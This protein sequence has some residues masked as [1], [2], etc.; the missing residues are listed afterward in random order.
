MKIKIAE[1]AGFCMGVRRAVNLVLKA[2]NEKKS[3]IYTYGPLIHNPQTLEL[4]A[5]LG[6]KILDDKTEKMPSS[7]ICII[8]AHGI[9]P[10]EKEKLSQNYEII[11]G[12]CPRVSKVQTLAK[13]AISQ[14]KEIII[15]G[16]KNHAEV[17]G[18]LGCC[19]NKGYVISSLDEVENLP[20]LSNYVILSQT[21][22][23]KKQFEEISN[24]IL[25]RY[26]SGEVINTICNATEVRQ[27]EVRKLCKMCSC[28]IVIG[29]KSS[30]NTNR[31]AEIAKKEGKKVFLIERIEDV[32]IKELSKCESIGITAGASTPNWLINEIID[33]LKSN[34][35][36]FYKFLKALSFFSFLQPLNFILLF[37]GFLNLI[38]SPLQTHSLLILSVFFFLLT[39]YNF[40]NLQNLNSFDFYYSIKGKFLKSNKNL[41]KILLFFSFIITLLTGIL[42]NY[43]I[44]YIFMI[45]TLINQIL[46]RSP[47]YF[48]F[49][50]LLLVGISFFLN[51]SFNLL[52]LLSLF[53]V[54]FIL[55]FIYFYLELVYYQTDGFL[56]SQFLFSF[57]NYK[58]DK[59]YTLIYGIIILLLFLLIPLILIKK[60]YL[61][62][63]PILFLAYKLI[64]FLKK[65][66]LGQIIYLENLPLT[67]S[68]LFFLL[69]FIFF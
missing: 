9:S 49:E 15:I 7:G 58:E 27:N 31:L 14:G 59:M 41:I 17:K 21:T 44:L 53:L 46:F 51:P 38:N 25:S 54:F 8:R 55:L 42:Y 66:P 3:P 12:T 32:P 39:K 35:S 22:Q 34:F 68:L 52:F 5:K 65:R 48:L 60:L 1:K 43:K 47:F 29:G 13:K 56:P 61:S 63:L 45:F 28:L 69:S 64:F 26:P 6:V 10:K 40:N 23:D 50:P 24:A 18:I 30:A 62:L 19:K 20:K 4:L 2:I 57:L 36:F 67:L 16:D 33:F 11:D 37:I